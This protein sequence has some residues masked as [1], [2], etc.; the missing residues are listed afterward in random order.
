MRIFEETL[1]KSITRGS[2]V[3]ARNQDCTY[4]TSEQHGKKYVFEALS[5][6][7]SYPQTSRPLGLVR[8]Q[9]PTMNWRQGRRQITN[10][11]QARFSSTYSFPKSLREAFARKDPIVMECDNR[12][13]Q[14]HWEMMV[15]PNLERDL[16]G[17]G[18][19]F[20]GIHPTITRQFRNRFGQLPERPPRFDRTLRILIVADTA[21]K[22]PLPASRYEARAI[23]ELFEGYGEFLRSSGS[24]RRVSVESL[25]GPE[26]A[27]L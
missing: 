23:Q 21:E 12:T 19:E 10:E 7:A 17:D 6:Q 13:A 8:S 26:I 24:D 5:D 22:M 20:L 3:A 25:V 27:D 1:I 11:K 9:M 15:V 14:L 4:I 16:V 2:D 18:F